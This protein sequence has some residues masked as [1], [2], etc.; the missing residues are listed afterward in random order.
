MP[1][2]IR[3]GPATRDTARKLRKAMT[4][5]EKRPWSRLRDRQ[6]ANFAFRK[7]VPLGPHVAD[8]CCLKARLVIEVDG[9]QHAEP[10]AYET[11]RTAWLEAQ[12][13]RALRFWN[14]EVLGNIEG[15]VETIARALDSSKGPV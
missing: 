13:Y 1:F 10:S 14:N 5:A 8:F 4:E 7:Q 6:I 9:G 15:V 2:Q 12:D 3:T 11:E